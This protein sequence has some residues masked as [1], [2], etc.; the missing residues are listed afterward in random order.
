VKN[1]LAAVKFG[2]TQNVPV[3]VSHG[4][5]SAGTAT[6]VLTARSES[7]PSKTMTARCEVTAR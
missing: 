1:A 6:V 4:A 2:E 5:G 3:Y 7:D